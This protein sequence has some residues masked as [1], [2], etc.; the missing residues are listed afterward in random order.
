MRLGLGRAAAAEQP[1]CVRAHGRRRIQAR[2]H[3]ARVDRREDL[4]RVGVRLAVSI[5]AVD[6][7]EH[8]R[9]RQVQQ[10]RPC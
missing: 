7:V 6:I 4:A 2:H 1:P 8:R 9:L 5:A 3:A 10:H